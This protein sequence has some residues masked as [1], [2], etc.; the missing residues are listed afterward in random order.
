VIPGSA[1]RDLRPLD[2]GARD[3]LNRGRGLGRTSARVADRPRV[4]VRHTA[5][6]AVACEQDGVGA[7]RPDSCSLAPLAPPARRRFPRR[8]AG[9]EAQPR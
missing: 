1:G 4:G 7:G 9:E 2:P 6:R 8:R 5:G 3:Q